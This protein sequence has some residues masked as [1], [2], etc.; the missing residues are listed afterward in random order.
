MGTVNYKELQDAAKAL[1]E[2]CG[3]TLKVIGGKKADLIKGIE[4][5]VSDGLDNIPEAVTIVHSKF[6]KGPAQTELGN[7][8]EVLASVASK[9]GVVV[10]EDDSLDTTEANIFESLDGMTEAEWNA[11]DTEVKEWDVEMTKLLKLKTEEQADGDDEPSKEVKEATEEGGKDEEV[12]GTEEEP[13]KKR[14]KPRPDFVFSQ[15]TNSYHIMQILKGLFERSKG[16]G[17]KL[18]DLK[19]ACVDAKVKSKN[20][21]SRVSSVIN[22]AALPEGGEQVKKANGLLYPKMPVIKE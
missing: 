18:D 14:A 4:K 12:S 19:A 7:T 8:M 2:A 1:N 21:P 11:L 15:N 16:E 3:T 17:I 13:V 5:A 20:I 9:I 6:P 22:Y 10:A